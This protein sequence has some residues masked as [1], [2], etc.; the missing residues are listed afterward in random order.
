[1]N[2]IKASISEL[3]TAGEDQIDDI[4]SLVIFFFKISIIVCT[5]SKQHITLTT[6][7]VSLISFNTPC[8]R[9][10]PKSTDRR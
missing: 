7:Y 4:S 5:P 3:E 9:K 10:L 1:M 2:Q 8:R 6:D